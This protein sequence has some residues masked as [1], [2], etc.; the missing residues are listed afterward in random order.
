VTGSYEE[1]EQERW[2]DAIRAAK[3]KREQRAD[4]GSKPASPAAEAHGKQK[5]AASKSP[6][7][8]LQQEPAIQA[9]GEYPGYPTPCSWDSCPNTRPQLGPP[10]PPQHH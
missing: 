7:P 2:R 3:Q 10:N 1:R 6:G 5:P 9:R 8:G 4:Q